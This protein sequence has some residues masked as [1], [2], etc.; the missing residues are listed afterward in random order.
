MTH[1]AESTPATAASDGP[2]GNAAASERS[3]KLPRHHRNVIAL[4]LVA[5]FVVILNETVM[6]VA[7]PVLQGDLGIEPAVGQWL[8]TAF[9][10]TMAIVIPTTGFLIRRI[11]TKTLFVAAMSLFSTGTAIAFF[12]QD[13]A[14]LLLGRIV[15]ASGTA[16][17]MPLLMTTVLTL[18]PPARRGQMMGNISIVISVA[19]ALGPTLSGFIIEHFGW[20]WIFGFVLPIALVSLALGARWIVPVTEIGHARIDLLSIPLAALG[21]GGLVYGLASIGESAESPAV[22]PPWVFFTVGALSLLVFLLRQIF[23]QRNDR[24]LLDL[25]VFSSRI[26]SVSMVAMLLSSLTLFG[27]IILIPLY[28]Q[29]VL[30]FDP[31][32]TGLITLPGGLLMGI[33]APFIGRIYDRRGPRPLVI[34]GTILVSIALWTLYLVSSTTTSVWWLVVANISMSVG[35]AATFT[36]VMTSGL[37]SLRP[38]LYSHG[39]AVLSTF[40]QVAAAAGTALFV[41][42]LSVGTATAVADGAAD[43]DGMLAGVRSAFLVGGFVSFA[44][45]VAGIFVTKPANELSPEVAHA[46]H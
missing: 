14:V 7:L 44:L 43:I 8:T 33:A 46:G 34:P 9:M 24:A 27:V 10:L 39:S 4:L 32:V 40:Q 23:L 17:M 1:S 2:S 20:H 6:S 18:V 35:L 45:I 16:I 11:T 28:A 21:F 37:G 29:N 13:F 42:V 41:T 26:F 12:S 19:P 15:Q 38:H 30:G 36:P 25:R 5:A 31:L 22:L 3:D